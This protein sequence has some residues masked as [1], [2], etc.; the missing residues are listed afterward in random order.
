MVAL[1]VC[2]P[3]ASALS[4]LTAAAGFFNRV[5]WL[6]RLFTVSAPELYLAP[7]DRISVALAGNLGEFFM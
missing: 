1:W 2:A 5:F 3:K 6:D 7:T 4:P